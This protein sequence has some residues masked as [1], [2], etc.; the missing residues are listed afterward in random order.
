MEFSEELFMIPFAKNEKLYAKAYHPFAGNF[1]CGFSE[2]ETKIAIQQREKEGSWVSPP[3][4]SYV[5]DVK[6]EELADSQWIS[7]EGILDVEMLSSRRR[8]TVFLSLTSSHVDWFTVQLRVHLADGEYQDINVGSFKPSENN[9][10]T[11]VTLSEILEPLAEVLADNP[12]SARVMLLAP[13][14]QGLEFSV[15]MFNIFATDAHSSGKQ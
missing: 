5:L 2:P 10:L 15:S 11:R 1:E 4:H 3:D 9:G 14:I 8:L 13:K 12:T 6:V 7:L